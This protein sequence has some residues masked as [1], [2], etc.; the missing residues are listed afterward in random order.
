MR[1]QWAGSWGVPAELWTPQ[2]LRLSAQLVFPGERSH[3]GWGLVLP[4]CIAFA[5]TEPAAF[6]PSCRADSQLTEA[7]FGLPS[8]RASAG[9]AS[10]GKMKEKHWQELADFALVIRLARDDD[11]D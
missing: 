10:Y 8:S 4:L 5:N 3:G 2:E 6:A 1:A 11:P 7:D 9:W